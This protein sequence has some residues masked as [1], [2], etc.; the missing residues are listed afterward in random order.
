MS[1]TG[2]KAIVWAL[3]RGYEVSLFGFTQDD[4]FHYWEDKQGGN[5]HNFEKEMQIIKGF[6]DEGKL[7]IFS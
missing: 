5:S 3:E 7:K 4:K 6:E 1:T 2:L